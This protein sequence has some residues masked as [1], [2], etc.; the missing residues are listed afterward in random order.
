MSLNV[1]NHCITIYVDRYWKEQRPQV[2]IQ[3]YNPRCSFMCQSSS[4][5]EDDVL[6]YLA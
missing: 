4:W 3:L 1:V 2:V 6:E 5:I